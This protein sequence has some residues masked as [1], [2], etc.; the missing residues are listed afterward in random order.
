MSYNIDHKNKQT[1]KQWGRLEYLPTEEWTEI[2]RNGHK[3]KYDSTLEM[4]EILT[5]TT[6]WVNWGTEC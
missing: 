5:S 3:M 6:A 2:M 1:N 4:R